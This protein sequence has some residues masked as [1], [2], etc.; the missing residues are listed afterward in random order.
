MWI[1]E[2]TSMDEWIEKALVPSFQQ[3]KRSFS[4]DESLVVRLEDD[5]DDDGDSD[6][7]RYGDSLP[8]CVRVVVEG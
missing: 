7:R 4:G 5:D 8:P 2:T 1:D 6:G 3:L